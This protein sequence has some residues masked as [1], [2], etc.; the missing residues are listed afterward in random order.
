MSPIRVAVVYPI[1]VHYRTPLFELVAAQPEVDLTVLY[2]RRNPESSGVGGDALPYPHRFLP[3]AGF[4]FQGR[5]VRVNVN[6]AVIAEVVRGR[7]DVL[8]VNGLSHPS[9]YLALVAGA[10]RRTPFIVWIESHHQRMA[11][12][13][14]LV[15]AAKKVVYGA[16]FRRASAAFMTGT[17]ARDY[18][19]SYGGRAERAFRVANTTGVVDVADAVA[20]IRG[21]PRSAVPT[22]LFVGRLIPAKG[23]PHLLDA[24]AMVASRALD[25]RMVVVGDGPLRSQLENQCRHLGVAARVTFTGF[26]PP[27]EIVA[28]YAMADIF[29]LP[30]LHETWGT[31]VNEAMAA[32]LPVITTS[33]VGASG[34]LVRDR[35]NGRVVAPGDAEA[36]AEAIIGLLLDQAGRARMA[37]RSRELMT[38]WTHEASAE[39]FVRGVEAAMADRPRSPAHSS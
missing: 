20:A 4:V 8:V 22:L 3:G 19:V 17:L 34:D 31:V 28:Q 35:D 18:F 25:F 9:T 29:V 12:A 15:E 36:L 1:P 10:T 13:P 32:S 39:A 11:P 27:E 5:D 16:I 14:A 2:C 38:G 21:G 7:F 24:L 6:P 37:A 26:L 23:L 30:S 33:V